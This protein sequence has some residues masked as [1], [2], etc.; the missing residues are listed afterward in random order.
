MRVFVPL[1]SLKSH[2]MTSFKSCLEHEIHVLHLHCVTLCY[3]SNGNDSIPKNMSGEDDM[4]I[5]LADA[6]I[7]MQRKAAPSSTCCRSA[8]A[9]QNCSWPRANIPVPTGTESFCCYGCRQG[10][11]LLGRHSRRAGSAHTR[12]RSSPPLDG[13]LLES[14]FRTLEINCTRQPSPAGRFWGDVFL[15]IF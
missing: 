9:L 7:F 8:G 14:S 4:D 12:Q 3:I 6:E 1:P 5:A 15:R 2:M 13:G 10:E 11:L